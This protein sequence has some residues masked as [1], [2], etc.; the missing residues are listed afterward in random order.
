[1]CGF[2]LPGFE[3]G[4]ARRAISLQDMPTLFDKV[5]NLV[6]PGKPIILLLQ[7][8]AASSD[9]S[10]PSFARTASTDW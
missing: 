5:A 4:T 6:S 7:D 1:M 9:I 8:W 3:P 10:T 2:T